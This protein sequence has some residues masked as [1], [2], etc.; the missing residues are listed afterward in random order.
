LGDFA[1]PVTKLKY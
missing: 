1:A